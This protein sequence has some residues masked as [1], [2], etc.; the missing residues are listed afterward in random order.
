MKSLHKRMGYVQRSPGSPVWEKPGNAAA[1]LL[2]P[3]AP[4]QKGPRASSAPEAKASPLAPASKGKPGTI[5]R[6]GNVIAPGSVYHPD[7][8]S[9]GHLFFLGQ[10]EYMTMPN[11]DIAR[12]SRG[13]VVDTSGRRMARFEASRQAWPQALKNLGV[14][15]MGKV[16]Q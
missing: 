5:V 9:A 11:G 4:H 13:D 10:H 16:S 2:A 12:A 8:K 6:G 14:D 15:A 1:A 7:T 3:T